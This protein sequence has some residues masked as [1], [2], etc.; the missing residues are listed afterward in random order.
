MSHVIDATYLNFPTKIKTV[1]F[2]NI[3]KS[4]SKKHGW[5]L[6][7]LSEAVDEEDAEEESSEDAVVEEQECPEVKLSCNILLCEPWLTE[8]IHIVNCDSFNIL[9]HPST[10]YSVLSDK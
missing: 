10:P 3:I 4:L 6:S 8:L 2:Q 1:F 9:H 5:E 7:E